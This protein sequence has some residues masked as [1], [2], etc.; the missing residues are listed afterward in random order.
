MDR[1]F[2]NPFIFP[3]DSGTIAW[4][5]GELGGSYGHGNARSVALVQSVL[6]CGGEVRGIRLLSRAGCERAFDAHP[7]GMDQ[8]L[9]FPCQWGMGYAVGGPTVQ[10]IFGN[11][12]DGRRIA[13]WGGSGGSFVV[14]DLDRHVTVAYVMNKHIESGDIDSRSAG[15]FKAAF[16]AV[17]AMK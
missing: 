3:Q 7:L 16:T 13:Y 4:R 8:V 17:N 2:F 9:G 11:L 1:V 12:F 6:S 10:A 5:R 14:N 15:V